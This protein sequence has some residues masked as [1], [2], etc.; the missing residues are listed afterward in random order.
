M[1]K[2]IMAV[3]DR[4]QIPTVGQC[5]EISYAQHMGMAIESLKEEG[6]KKETTEKLSDFVSRGIRHCDLFDILYKMLI[7]DRHIESAINDIIFD[8]IEG[9]S[10]ESQEFYDF[11][12]SVNRVNEY[13]A[14][15]DEWINPMEEGEEEINNISTVHSSWEIGGGAVD[16][17]SFQNEIRDDEGNLIDRWVE[18]I[19]N[20]ILRG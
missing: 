5:Q 3:C 6:V 8:F 12:Y 16:Q 7:E 17:T 19:P 15:V 14:R 18:E 13:H 1:K 11:M 9:G 2:L 10:I 20:S 4:L